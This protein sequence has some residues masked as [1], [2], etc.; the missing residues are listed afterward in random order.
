MNLNLYTYCNYTR[1]PACLDMSE[2]LLS[3]SIAVFILSV[4]FGELLEQLLFANL[5][6]NHHK[7]YYLII[8]S[9]FTLS[10]LSSLMIIVAN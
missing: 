9:R 4:V 5:Y 10:W 7:C 6:E 1:L 8:T 2:Y 3:H